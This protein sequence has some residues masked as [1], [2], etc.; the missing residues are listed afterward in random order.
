V[1]SYG[2]EAFEALDRIVRD[3]QRADLLAPV[4]VVVERGGLALSLRRRL[5]SRPRGVA[6][7]R[8]TTWDRLAASLAVRPLSGC[9]RLTV[10]ASAE[11]EAVRSALVEDAPHRL[12]GALGQ[13]ATLR[14][15][16][17]TYRELAAV[18]EAALDKLAAQ[19]ARAG[20]VVRLVR[21]ARRILAGCLS[22]AEVIETAAAEVR[23]APRW[24]AE[25]CGA[26]VVHLPYR[27]GTPEIGLLQSLAACMEAH[28]ILGATGDP[29]ADAPTREL[30]LRLVGTD[31]DGGFERAVVPAA[32]SV[33]AAPSADAEVL[34][35]LRDLMGH[36]ARNVPLERMALVHSGAP[37]YPQLIHDLLARAGIPA[38]GGSGRPL[39]ATLPGRALLGLLG[40]PDRDWRRDDVMAWLASA[41]LLH[42]G[43]PVAVAEWDELSAE[44]GIVSGIHQWNVRL[45]AHAAAL[46]RAAGRRTPG[47][48]VL[49]A[50]DGAGDVTATQPT[51]TLETAARR[52]DDLRAFAAALAERF[53]QP[54]AS[55]SAW[56]QWART[57]L[58]DLLGPTTRH[59]SWPHEDVVALDAVNEALG[60]IGALDVLS[61]S[62]PA[63]ADFRAALGA[64]LD[65][66]AP[67]TVRFG[68]GLL[69]GRLHEAV[70]LDLDVIYVV[71]MADGSFP[72]VEADDVLVPDRERERAGP[73]VPRRV[74]DPARARREYLAALAS[75]RVR[76]LSYAR[77]DQRY[78]RPLRP[79]RALL[80]SL[81]MRSGEGGRRSARA[82]RHG[83][84]ASLDAASM[85]L[86]TSFAEAV[87]AASAGAEPVSEDDWR[88]QA[89][90]RWVGGGGTVAEHAFGRDDHVLA[91]ALTVRRAR[92]SPRL[93]RFDGLAGALETPRTVADMVESATGLEELA[94]CPRRYFFARQL[95]IS[96]RKAPE[97][98]FEITPAERGAI[99][100][101]VLERLVQEEI[102]ARAHGAERVGP[103]EREGPWTPSEG[104]GPSMPSEG[105]GP[106][107]PSEGEGPSMPTEGEG[108]SMPEARMLA[109]AEEEFAESCRRGATGHPA[110]WGLVRS[111][112]EAD[113]R[114]QLHSDAEHRSVAG[115]K[116]IAVELAF[117]PATGVDV[118]VRASRGMVH[119]RGRIDRVDELADGSVAVLDYKSGRKYPSAHGGEEP[120]SRDARLQLPVYALAAKAAYGAS[121]R[122]RAGYWFVGSPTPPQWSAIDA[123]LEAR[124]TGMVDALCDMLEHAA[125]PGRPGPS[126][127]RSGRGVNCTFCPYD[128]MCPPERRTEWLH[129]RGDPVLGPYRA[130]V[131]ET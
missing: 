75:A 16:A 67:E 102:A 109:I 51:G 131:G 93:T 130:L 60:R 68:H 48:F 123:E 64:E 32:T 40:L 101:R 90:T 103:S 63:F 79:A 26:V 84:A 112:I 118:A 72:V 83:S 13:P 105:E 34:M 5:A 100:H 81:E 18:P 125:F 47:V 14:A 97:A 62:P 52:C 3:V 114:V 98:L 8:C 15:L 22:P 38:H 73:E 6:N 28:V 10:S 23:R 31:R 11:L 117:G 42:K 44:A 66:P 70:G 39:S 41:P 61:A 33:R 37:P 9:S 2:D 96:A 36:N 55:W 85:E 43:T 76:V 128:A 87:H 99:I 110:L 56:S 74:A 71:G 80:E 27:L 86:V 49:E 107:M 129:K 120:R 35:A 91:G 20:E 116:P 45:T 4:T 19:S 12:S 95:R 29:R 1:H 94:R 24:A 77:D 88:L 46:R 82:L 21:R 58:A 104:E 122:I 7:V 115:A 92:R 30:L 69:V 78:G 113:L 65:L 54:P 25:R 17:R 121:R 57:V 127:E 106:S 59:A 89:L 124:V 126:D 111:R 108:P 50:R 53:V 119:F